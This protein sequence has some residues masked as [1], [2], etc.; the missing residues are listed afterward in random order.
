MDQKLIIFLK[1]PEKGKVKTRLARS[2]GDEQAACIY[3]KLAEDTV[4]S[5]RPIA[6]K[7]ADIVIAFDPPDRETEI[8]K[9]MDGPFEFISQGGGDLGERLSRVS[10]A[11]FRDGAQR[12][13]LIGSDCAELDVLTISARFWRCRKRIRRCR[14]NL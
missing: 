4:N 1:Y 10:H 5:L 14:R 2:I 7:A 6:G 8:R 11:S 3:K 9:W 12:V 13:V